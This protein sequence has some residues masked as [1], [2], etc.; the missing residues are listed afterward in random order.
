MPSFVFDCS[1][2]CKG[3]FQTWSKR[4]KFLILPDFPGVPKDLMCSLNH[5]NRKYHSGIHSLRLT[6]ASS[7]GSTSSSFFRVK[8]MMR[9]MDHSYSWTDESEWCW[10]LEHQMRDTPFDQFPMEVRY[11]HALLVFVICNWYLWSHSFRGPSEGTKWRMTR[12]IRKRQIFPSKFQ[13]DVVMN[14]RLV[15]MSRLCSEIV[16]RCRGAIDAFAIIMS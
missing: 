10:Y 9:R 2:K 8:Y 7:Q 5:S 14:A 1:G 6:L 12:Y 13:F 11:I 3:Q 16:D 4:A 15:R